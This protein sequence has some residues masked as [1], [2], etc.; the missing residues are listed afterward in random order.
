MNHWSIK[1]FDHVVKWSI[2]YILVIDTI[3]FSVATY[4]FHFKNVDDWSLLLTVVIWGAVIGISYYI[5]RH[6]K[7]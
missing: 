3:I 6:Y 2:L 7:K 5:E 4:T 1:L